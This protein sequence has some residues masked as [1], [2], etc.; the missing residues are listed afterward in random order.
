MA[1]P[2]KPQW[3]KLVGDT[4]GLVTN[5]PSSALSEDQVPDATGLDMTVPG[6]LKSGTQPTATTLVQKT[7]TIGANTYYLHYRRLWRGASTQIIFGAP[8]YTSVYYPQGKGWIDCTDDSESVMARPVPIG[9]SGLIFFKTT[10]AYILP[11]ADNL[12]GN[13]GNPIFTQEVVISDNSYACELDGL[14]YFVNTNGLFTVDVQGNVK[15]ISLPI[16]GSVT[17][18]A[19]TVDYAN[20]YVNIGSALSYRVSDGKFFKYS[21]ST[22]ALYSRKLHN[23][24]NTVLTVSEVDFEFDK[25]STASGDIKFKYQTEERGYSLEQTL[26]VNNVRT[27]K[28]HAHIKIPPD[29][30]ISWQLQLTAIPSNLKIKAIWVQV[31]GYTQESR[32]S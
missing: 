9:T 29:T 20:K 21:G 3:V 28:E 5:T 27:Q 13:F 19:I 14:V 15:E 12:G 2:A 6:Y 8:E 10:G 22:F 16:D 11:S 26:P 18:A 7:Y 30:G 25:S 31:E 1:V 4:P 17:P 24:D 23:R 32:D